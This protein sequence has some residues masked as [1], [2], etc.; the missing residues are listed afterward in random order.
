MLKKKKKLFY[1]KIHNFHV[2]VKELK[3]TEKSLHIH[4]SSMC[5]CLVLNHMIQERIQE[6]TRTHTDFTTGRLRIKAEL[7]QDKIFDYG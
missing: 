2:S 1:K 3:S 7:W 4:S 6:C 5:A